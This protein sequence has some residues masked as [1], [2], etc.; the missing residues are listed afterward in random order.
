MASARV[1]VASRGGDAAELEA[2]RSELLG[3]AAVSWPA[4]SWLWRGGE[5]RLDVLLARAGAVVVAVDEAPAQGGVVSVALDDSPTQVLVARAGEPLRLAG[6]LVEGHHVIALTS[7]VGGRV[8][9]GEVTL[10]PGRR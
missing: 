7:L 9:P 8:F 10:E 5:A 4:T 6:T 3:L 1:E 2:A